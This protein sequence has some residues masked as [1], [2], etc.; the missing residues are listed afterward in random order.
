M[1]IFII[2]HCLVYL[3]KP[4][5]DLKMQRMTTQH[6]ALIPDALKKFIKDN[7][8][9]VRSPGRINLI[10]EHTDYNEGF[11]LPAAIDKAA[12]IVITS[13]SSNDIVLHSIDMNESFN[14]T[15]DVIEKSKTAWA[16]FMLG[17]VDQF[18][19]SG[20][21]IPGFEAALIG[22][23]PI[24]AGLSSSAAVECAMAFALNEITNAGL[25]K[26]TMVKMAQKAEQTFAGVMCGIMDMFASTFGKKNHV[27]KLDCRS[28]DY[29]YKPL[30]LGSYKILLLNTNVKHSLASSAYN[31]RRQECEQGVAW[32]RE[33][34]PD[35]H[36][37]RDVTIGML[38]EHVLPKNKLVY[39]R[40]RFIVEEIERL[41]AGCKDLEK[42]DIKAFGK[43]MFRTHEGLSKEYEVSCDELDFL[44][45]TV[46]D[47]ALIVGARMM[48]GGFGGC[49]INIIEEAAIDTLVIKLKPVYQKKFGKELVHYIAGIEDGTSII[50]HA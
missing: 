46:K 19:K 30:D 39:K 26:L 6:T 22:D 24:G 48:G 14:T 47:N 34:H 37:L 16:N 15:T 38:N 42:G 8:V 44:V 20:I 32:V 41:L 45:D 9:V 18:Q 21:K 7:S 49:T 43:K 11:V 31:T 50:N 28:L 29:E 27:I 4:L 10:G 13:N 17:V 23:V 5:K 35:V 3:N 40:C 12:Y 33:H 36:S 1:T 2:F 25:D